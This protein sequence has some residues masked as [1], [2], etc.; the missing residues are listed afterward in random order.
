MTAKKITALA[1]LAA[2]ALITFIIESLL[3]P[4]LFFAPGTKLG[5]AN[6]FVFLAL[7][8]YGKKEAFAV[9]LVKCVLG[10]VFSGNIFSLYYSLI[11]GTV[12]LSLAIALFTFAYGKIGVITISVFCAVA[13]NAAQVA[14]AAVISRTP[15]L[16]TYY[17]PL[18]S[19]AGI[20]AGVVTGICV[21]LIIKRLPD[22]L[23]C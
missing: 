17:L 10:A 7:I 19:A 15:L 6:I 12:S 2:L 5:I 18:A 13:H 21:Y 1:A 16:I 11:A 14:V 8:I 9:L 22:N 23:I 3:P 20:I 4:A